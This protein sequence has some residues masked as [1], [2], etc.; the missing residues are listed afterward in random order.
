[1]RRCA[2]GALQD[3]K[4]AESL[5]LIGR[6]LSDA[7]E[8]VRR[9]AVFAL[10]WRGDAGAVPLIERALRD[11]ALGVREEANDALKTFKAAHPVAWLFARN[12]R[13][14]ARSGAG[15]GLFARLLGR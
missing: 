4:D 2:A 5:R 15:K 1:M 11:E 13:P 14:A 7:D 9:K 6:A 10:S 3:R 12:V 8:H